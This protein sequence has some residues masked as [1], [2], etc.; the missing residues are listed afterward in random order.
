MIKYAL[1]TKRT[2]EKDFYSY[3]LLSVLC[4]FIFP[5]LKA[6]RSTFIKQSRTV[7]APSVISISDHVVFHYG[8]IKYGCYIF[9]STISKVLLL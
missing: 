9:P 3:Y 5:I 6:S 8:F 4:V 7:A 2:Q 1:Q